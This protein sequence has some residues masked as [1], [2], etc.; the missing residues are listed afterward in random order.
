MN[1]SDDDIKLLSEYMSVSR[2][3]AI[4][5][6]DK[7]FNIKLLRNGFDIFKS[8]LG[9]ISKKA[10]KVVNSLTDEIN[11]VKNDIIKAKKDVIKD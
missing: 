11:N 2:E 10:D 4:D 1:Y 9:T 5:M 6:L 7:G 8:K 3:K